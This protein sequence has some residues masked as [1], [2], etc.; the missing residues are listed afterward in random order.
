MDATKDE[1]T[2]ETYDPIENVKAAQNAKVDEFEAELKAATAVELPELE[3]DEI[4]QRVETANAP[5]T[6]EENTLSGVSDEQVAYIIQQYEKAKAAEANKSADDED[7]TV[8]SRELMIVPDKRFGMV[9]FKRKG[10]GRIPTILQGLWAQTDAERSLKLY[11]AGNL[12]PSPL[13][14][15]NTRNLQV[16]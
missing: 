9:I 11:T 2:E 8:V 12:K 7:P 5:K 14:V 3:P 13:Q 1:L 16:N 10:G 15:V 6:E 4:V